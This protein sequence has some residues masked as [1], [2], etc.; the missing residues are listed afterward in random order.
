MNN[1]SVS[2]PYGDQESI[3]FEHIQTKMLNDGIEKDKGDIKHEEE[4]I[5]EQI[6]INNSLLIDHSTSSL[7]LVSSPTSSD[8]ESSI[9]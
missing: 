1:T 9:I 8:H 7:Q 2:K 6:V 3:E 5:K 4:E